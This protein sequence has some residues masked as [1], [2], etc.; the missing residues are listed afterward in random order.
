MAAG[1]AGPAPPE[2]GGR[3]MSPVR[4]RLLLVGL[5]PPE[6]G[7]SIACGVACHVLDLAEQAAARGFETAVLAPLRPGAP[8]AARG[9]RLID[10]TR[11]R[12]RRILSGSWAAWGP[13][14]PPSDFLAS[15][16]WRD[17][18][19]ILS[20][21][22]RINEA[23]EAIRPDIVHIHPLSH[24]AGP[25]LGELP[26]ELPVVLTDHGFWQDL[27]GDGDLEKV[28]ETARLA[29]G[30]IAVSRHCA[31]RQ[32]ELGLVFSGLKRIIRNPVRPWP[33]VGDAPRPGSGRKRVLFVA[34]VDALTRKGLE[35]LVQAF[36]GDRELRAGAEL[37]VITE[38]KAGGWA[39]RAMSAAGIRGEVRPLLPC[40]GMI[41]AYREAD[42]FV[43]P[44]RSEAFPL[45]FLE[46][47]AAGTPVVGF[48]PAVEELREILG[49][50]AGLPFDA[51]AGTAAGLA[52]KIKRALAEPPNR[53]GLAA[54]TAAAF[55][56]DVVFPAYERFYAEAR[57]P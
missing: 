11:S 17:R 54:A 57:R 29:A 35:I 6:A 39:R 51:A 21:T 48:G 13:K 32:D 37:F 16:G 24:P 56:W 18:L 44:S 7:G 1:R 55:S 50:D 3:I 34:G 47:L 53:A 19:S 23:I 45:V 31:D 26:H 4:P 27:R 8:A 20:W 43:L 2:P 28:R 5:V 15:R 12:L 14:R 52:E 10:A 22:E 46:S 33:R 42:V 40:R 41:E 49:P 38:P 36:A 25:G 9:V 30:V